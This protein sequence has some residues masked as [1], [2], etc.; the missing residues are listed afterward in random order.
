MAEDKIRWGIIGPGGI[1]RAFAAGVAHSRTGKLVAIGARD[2]KK[3]GY[4]EHFA[5]ARVLDGYQAVLDDPEVDAVYISTPHPQ[6]AEW[7]IKAANAGKHALVEKPMGLTAYEADAMFDAAR[8]AGTF[9]GEAFM[10]RLHP[11]TARLV[12]LIKAG[13]IGEVRMIQSSFGFAMPSFDPKHRLYANDL[14]GGGILDVGCYPVSMARLIAGAA[15]GKA[16]LDPVQGRRHGPSRRERRRRMGGGAAAVPE[17]H[18]RRMRLRGVAEA[19]KRAARPR[20]QGPHRGAGLLV[21]RRGREGGVGKIDVIAANGE[22]RR[23]R[24]RS[25]AGSIPSRPTPPATP[26]APAGR[27]S[28][29]RA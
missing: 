26:S 4:E 28:P 17:R 5:G 13:E 25:R 1:A 3:P 11:Q 7:A 20:H 22:T 18:P 2:P 14:A 6:H 10:Y 16:F 8:R 21:R 19:G 24:S 23:S 29:L 9:M 27:S 12:E 15:A